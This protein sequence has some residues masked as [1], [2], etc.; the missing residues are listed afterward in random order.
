MAGIILAKKKK[1]KKKQPICNLHMHIYLFDI[2]ANSAVLW[3]APLHLTNF[4]PFAQLVL[5]DKCAGRWSILFYPLPCKVHKP[6]G[7]LVKH[8]G[9]PENFRA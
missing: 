1:K 4:F 5:A 3:A 8:K 6:S 9:Q 2:A 7:I